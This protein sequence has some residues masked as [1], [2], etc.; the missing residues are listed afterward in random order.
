MKFVN[1]ETGKASK[2]VKSNEGFKVVYPHGVGVETF[3]SIRAIQTTLD[4]LYTV[5]SDYVVF[6]SNY[7]MFISLETNEKYVIVRD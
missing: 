3:T 6:L 7:V 2:F 5:W 1:L 4:N